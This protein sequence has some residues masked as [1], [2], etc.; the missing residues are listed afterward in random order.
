MTVLAKATVTL[1]LQDT[2]IAFRVDV[3]PE[4]LPESTLR[5]LANA[6]MD[7]LNAATMR[8]ACHQAFMQVKAE[9]QEEKTAQLQRIVPATWGTRP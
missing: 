9:Q 3:D 1:E 6:F 4:E 5:L 7:T 8:Q 2:G